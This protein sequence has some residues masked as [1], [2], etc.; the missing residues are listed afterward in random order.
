MDETLCEL[1]ITNTT[2]GK[3][4][5]WHFVYLRP[6]ANVTNG[7]HE[8]CVARHRRGNAPEILCTLKNQEEAEALV[9]ML[10][11][12]CHWYQ[13]AASFHKQPLAH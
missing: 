9:D 8:L 12:G 10:S 7:Q 3:R 13:T 11:A 2:T 5:S 4:T 6:R 1:V